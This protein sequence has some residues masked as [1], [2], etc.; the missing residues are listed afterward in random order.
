VN[1]LHIVNILYIVNIVNI[2]NIKRKCRRMIAHQ[3]GVLIF[4][5]DWFSIYDENS[6]KEFLREHLIGS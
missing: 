5:N 4:T 1:I 2:V 6:E 3:I